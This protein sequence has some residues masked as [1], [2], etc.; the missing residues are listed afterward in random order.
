MK[1]QGTETHIP[2]FSIVTPS[3]NQAQYVEETIRSVINQAGDFYIEYFV[4][5]GGSTD[6]SVDVIRRYDRLIKEGALKINCRGVSFEWSSGKDNG[7]TDAI[8]KGFKRASGDFISWI[9]SDDLYFD[10]AFAAVAEHFQKNQDCAFVYGDGDVINKSGG[11][12]WVWKSRTYD[13]NLLKTYDFRRDGFTNYIMQQSTFWRR[14]V[15]DSIGLLDDAFHYA[16]DYEYWLRAGAARLNM[17][18][19][20]VK[21]GKFRMIQDTKSLSS[22]TIFWPEALEIFRRHNGAAEMEPFLA[23]FFFNEG[24]HNGC[25]IELTRAQEEKV[26]KIWAALERG[27]QETL[28]EKAENAFQTARLML[29]WKAYVKGEKKKASVIYKAAIRDN[30]RLLFHPHSRR[31]IL[32]GPMGRQYSVIREWFKNKLKAFAKRRSVNK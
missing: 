11:L 1:T 13:Y 15:H 10:G 20:P 3:Y 12:Q 18:Y 6:G 19:I 9:N 7:Q 23:Y 4:M 26:F 28:R 32:E 2:V 29:A 22:P 16:M 5:D 31:Y 14:S 25:D 27:E 8:N 30:P 21:L 17:C 24:K